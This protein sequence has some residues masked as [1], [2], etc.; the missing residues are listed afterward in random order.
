MG[1]RNRNRKQR[2]QRMSGGMAGISPQWRDDARVIFEYLRRD[3]TDAYNQ[4]I[5]VYPE[6]GA[7]HIQRTAPLIYRLARE[8]STLYLREP[9]RQF[10]GLSNDEAAVIKAEY[11]RARVNRRFRTAQ[12]HLS[13]LANATVW[14]WLTPT[15][16]RLL[17]IP[18]HDQWVTP[19]GLIAQ[20]VA[21]IAEWRVRFNVF[22]DGAM[23]P[24][25]ALITANKAVWES[26]PWQGNGVW[27]D[28]G[29]NPFGRIPVALLRGTDPA[30]GEF[31]SPI[32]QDLRDSQR[33]VNHDFTDIG[34]VRRKQGFGQAY[35]KGVNP[36]Q[37]K[38]IKV[39]PERVV[40]L[41]DGAEFGFA[42]AS[43][44]LAGSSASLKSFLEFVI[45]CNGMNP[46]TVMKSAGI[47]A[48]AKI[49]EIQDREVER[50]RSVDEFVSAEQEVFELIAL[51]LKYRN[52]GV[53]VV[54]TTGVTV[55]VTHREPIQPSDPT[56]AAQAA[57]QRI[58]AHLDTAATVLA[59]ELGIPVAEAQKLVLEY[60]EFNQG[61]TR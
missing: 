55:K 18:I 5:E 47:T 48:L 57:V 16:Y 1:R 58:G 9:E 52:E 27:V 46:A 25:I 38:K 42:S 45:A 33:A 36:A 53:P 22:T 19:Q 49:I 59:R 32:P 41:P 37:A 61:L 12:E 20:E 51:A 28:D 4:R 7:N 23:T 3:M 30:P 43:P 50:I 34:E 24:A 13:V 29:S 2:A 54:P 10:V 21:D 11:L 8:L 60:R 26:G 39:G 35:A 17:V 6:T 40:G 14:V 31:L 44:D 15:D 56:S